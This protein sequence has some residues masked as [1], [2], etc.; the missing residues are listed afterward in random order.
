MGGVGAGHR[1]CRELST[2]H[3]LMV[4]LPSASVCAL[5]KEA[6]RTGLAGRAGNYYASGSD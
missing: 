1:V 4:P 6:L 5:G 3:E 2:C